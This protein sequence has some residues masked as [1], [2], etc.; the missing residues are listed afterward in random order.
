MLL[1]CVLVLAA[2][3]PSFHSKAHCASSPSET[4][5]SSEGH[6]GP[7]PGQLTLMGTYSFTPG[8]RI[9]D[10]RNGARLRPMSGD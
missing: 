10:R 1:L 3:T 6:P 5:Q 2:P 7:E 9:P 4:A 8:K